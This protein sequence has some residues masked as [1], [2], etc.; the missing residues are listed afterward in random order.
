MNTG[1]KIKMIRIK[2]GL[3]QKSLASK[4]GTSPQNLAQ[5]ENNK[6]NPKIGTL[7]RI[8]DV[9]GVSIK[10]LLS[11]PDSLPND[12]MVYARDTALERIMFSK[13]YT[14]GITEDTDELYINFPDGILK[15]ENY[16]VNTLLEDIESF[17]DFKL[18]EL[19]R[20]YKDNFIPKKHFDYEKRKTK[21]TYQK[22]TSDHL[23]V[24]AAHVRT[25]VEVT[26]EM[27][28]YDDDLLDD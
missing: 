15:V 5:Y 21:T 23:A 26:D 13:G 10:D 9:L 6:R 3:T 18:H 7:Q 17:T 12:D 11:D 22:E 28:K 25:D 8:A 27:K 20:K 1:E 2:R 19:K 14:F 24:N 4:L 16:I